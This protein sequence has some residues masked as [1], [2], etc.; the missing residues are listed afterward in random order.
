MVNPVRGA[1]NQRRL[2]CPVDKFGLHVGR[3]QPVGVFNF[4]SPDQRFF[5]KDAADLD[6]FNPN[7]VI[8]ENSLNDLRN[9]A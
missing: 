5:M 9:C 6:F 7:G 1:F 8:S 3:E 4:L 2:F